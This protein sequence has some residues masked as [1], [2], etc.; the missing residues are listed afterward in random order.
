MKMS[1]SSLLSRVHPSKLSAEPC[2]ACSQN[3]PEQPI[4][5]HSMHV[6]D[7]FLC[8]TETADSHREDSRFEPQ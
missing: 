8:N 5:I 1:S 2:T 7:M 4:C 6:V 3:Y